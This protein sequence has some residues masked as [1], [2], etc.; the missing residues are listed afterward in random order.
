[1]QKLFFKFLPVLL[2]V[3]AGLVSC[4]KGS[5]AK[6]K[7]ELLTQAS[8]KFDKAVAVGIGDIS[9]QV[10]ACLK[11]NI[12]TF[13]SNGNGS[14]DESTNVCTPSTAGSFTWSF[15]SNETVLQVSTTLFGGSGT[16]DIVSLTETNFVLSQVMTFPPLPAMTVEITL[17][18]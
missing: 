3:S 5:K 1:M 9:S 16:F 11:D 6:T 17:K 13:Q 2:M 14:V 8:W 10:Q 12:I 4:S 7:T 18:H 15:Q